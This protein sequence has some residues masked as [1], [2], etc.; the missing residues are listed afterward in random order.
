ML[1]KQREENGFLLCLK[2]VKSTQQSCLHLDSPKKK[3]KRRKGRF[4]SFCKIIEPRTSPKLFAH[5]GPILPQ[6]GL[7]RSQKPGDLANQGFP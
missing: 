1:K 4:I 7:T 6:I 5:S 3:R 2:S